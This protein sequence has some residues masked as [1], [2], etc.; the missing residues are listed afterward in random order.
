MRVLH[1]WF[2]SYQ[3]LTRS[4]VIYS[5]GMEINLQMD[6]MDL[7]VAQRDHG[8]DLGRPARGDITSQSSYAHQNNRHGGKG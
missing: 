4:C 6:W 5:A 3:L 7:I 1:V 2:C 8:I